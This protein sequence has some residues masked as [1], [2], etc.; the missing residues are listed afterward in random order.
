MTNPGSATR[1]KSSKFKLQT[2][3]FDQE[4]LK[5]SVPIDRRNKLLALASKN[6]N[7]LLMLYEARSSNK[8]NLI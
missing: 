6:G 2:W 7:S 5:R 3:L 8:A 1:Q 4:E